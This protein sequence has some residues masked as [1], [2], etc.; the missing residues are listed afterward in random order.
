MARLTFYEREQIEYGKRVGLSHREIGRRIKR[1]HRV[2]DREVK[3]NSSPHLSYTAVSAQ[4]SFERRQRI[5]NTKKIEKLEN[6]DLRDYVVNHLKGNWSPEQIAGRLKKHN[7]LGN[8]KSVSH[9]SIYEY[10]YNGE[11][12]YEYLY[13]HLRT[14]R[15]KRRKRFNRKKRSKITIKNRISIHDRPL[16]VDNKIRIGDWESDSLIFS[17]QRPIVSVQYERS[18]MLCRLHKLPN[19]TAENTENAIWDSISSLPQ[20]LWKTITRD[21]GLENANHQ[22]TSWMFGVQS[23]FC[24]GYASWQKGGVENINKLIRQ[25]LPRKTDL[26]KLHND[27]IFNIQ[28]QLNNRPRKSL[29]YLTPNEIIDNHHKVGH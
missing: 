11:G 21:N 12:R 26:A 24:D 9:E 19:K 13:P 25:Y 27:D 1:D 28:E 4:R 17:K 16:T 23:F 3:N 8:N 14:K 22:D 7:P 20:P 5:T 29:N 18:S 2:I 6:N 10:I 15:P